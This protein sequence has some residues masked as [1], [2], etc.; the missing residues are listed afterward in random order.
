MGRKKLVKV[1]VFSIMFS[2]IS[3]SFA[4]ASTTLSVSES[5]SHNQDIQQ[6]QTEIAE[7]EAEYFTIISGLSLD[8]AKHYGFDET[9]SVHFAHLEPNTQVAYN[10]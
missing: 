3:Y 10:F 1:L 2:F 7:L 4:I 9:S 8:G 6:L 5:K